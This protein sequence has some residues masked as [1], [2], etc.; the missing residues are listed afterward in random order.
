M[1]GIREGAGQNPDRRTGNGDWE[2]PR[3]LFVQ[4]LCLGRAHRSFVKIRL[5]PQMKK[6][7]S[8]WC[9]SRQNHN[10]LCFVFYRGINL[11]NMGS[12]LWKAAKVLARC[13]PGCPICLKAGAGA[14]FPPTPASKTRLF[15]AESSGKG[16]Y[17]CSLG[18]RLCELWRLGYGFPGRLSL[19]KTND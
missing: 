5:E 12:S 11:P 16:Q 19:D 3:V 4:R 18:V 13:G 14:A 15:L 7:R 2:V 10:I 6:Y 17:R 9:L 8:L 1:Q